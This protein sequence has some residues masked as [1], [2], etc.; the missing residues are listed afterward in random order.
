[1]PLDWFPILRDASAE[2]R[3]HFVIECE[4]TWV[5]FPLLN[6]EVT[7]EHLLVCREG[8]DETGFLLLCSSP[9]RLEANA[10]ALIRRLAEEWGITDDEAL[11]MVRR[12]LSGW[13]EKER[14][15]R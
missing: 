7:V 8:F 12:N 9:Q 13:P 1:M 14:D 3:G 15:R 2:E 4:R 5:G 10:A 6:T 11:E